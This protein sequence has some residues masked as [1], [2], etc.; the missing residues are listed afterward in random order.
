MRAWS[1]K[2]KGNETDFE[3]VALYTNERWYVTG[4]KSPNALDTD[5]FVGWLVTTGFD[6]DNFVELA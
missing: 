1:H 5:E 4:A 2:F 3:Y 6:P